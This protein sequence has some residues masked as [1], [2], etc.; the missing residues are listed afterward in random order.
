MANIEQVQTTDTF[1]Q[2]RTK[3]NANDQELE[4]RIAA[5]AASINNLTVSQN[6]IFYKKLSYGDGSSITGGYK[7]DLSSILG[8]S[9]LATG[10]VQ[11]AVNG[12]YYDSN[13]VQTTISGS[14][15]YIEQQAVV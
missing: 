6:S 4:T 10:S 11:F 14:S 8:S 7:F 9:F 12:I 1:K 15:F 2:G 3:W 5:N 13:D